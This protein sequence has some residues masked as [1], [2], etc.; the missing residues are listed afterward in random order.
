MTDHG[1]LAHDPTL[2][3]AASKPVDTAAV[4]LRPMRPGDLRRVADLEI[5]LFGVGAWT[6]GMLESELA[7]PS[8]YIVAVKPGTIPGAD[9]VIGYAGLQFDGEVADISTIGVAP[10]AQRLGLGSML[11]DALHDH[12]RILGAHSVFL[13]VAVNNDRAI[14]MYT[15]YGYQNVGLRKRYYQPENLDAYVMRME[16]EYGTVEPPQ[17]AVFISAAELAEIIDEPSLRVLDVRWQLGRSDGREQHEIAHIPGAV[18]VDMDTEL[19]APASVERGRHPLPSIADFEFSVRKWGVT[20]DSTIVVY[21]AVG[22][23]SAARLWWMLRNAGLADVRILDGGINAWSSAGHPTESG[24]VY[25]VETFIQLTEGA[26]PTITID[27]AEAWPEE[28]ILVDARAAE[29]YRGD[30]EPI[31]PR[32]GHIPGAVNVPTFSHLN[33]N[34]TLKSRSQLI[35]TFVEAGIIDPQVQ[36]DLDDAIALDQSVAVYCGSGVTASHEIA[37]LASLGIEAALFPGSWSQWSNDPAR[38]AVTGEE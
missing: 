21:D 9:R 33:E 13:D 26:M 35:E 4:S 22:G 3:Q 11:M 34:G 14:A 5:E 37:V 18:Y 2:T 19:A 38:P 24:L 28:G 15:K 17:S 29:R 10:E 12:A 27:E 1:S 31:D 6:Y 30:V 32:A 25:A 20:Q 23:T 8:T 16:L 36:G 7:S